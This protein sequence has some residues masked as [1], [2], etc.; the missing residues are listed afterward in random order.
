MFTCSLRDGNVRL[1][2]GVAIAAAF[3]YQSTRRG[4][5]RKPL[6]KRK[7][8]K[9]QK[10]EMRLTLKGDRSNGFSA[11]AASAAPAQAPTVV[12]PSLRNRAA[13]VN[14]ENKLK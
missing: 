14:Y 1:T 6:K 10:K 5:I 7:K 11:Q 2:R 3:T 9:Q 13:I 8:K 4:Y 12:T